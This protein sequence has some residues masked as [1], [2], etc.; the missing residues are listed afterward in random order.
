M[1]EEKPKNKNLI[2]YIEIAAVILLICFAFFDD[3]DPIYQSDIVAANYDAKKDEA[4]G[5][6]TS[7]KESRKLARELLQK[8]YEQLK[9]LHNIIYRPKAGQWMT[10][11]DE[12]GQAFFDYKKEKGSKLK[13]KNKLIYIKKVGTFTESQDKVFNKTIEFIKLYFDCQVKLLEE[14]TESEIPKEFK[15]KNPYEGHTQVLTDYVL[16][17]LLLKKEKSIQEDALAV[18]ALTSFDLYPHDDWNFVFGQAYLNKKAGVWSIYR[19]GDP[20]ESAE[21][22]TRC[23]LRTI[24]TATHEISH[25]LGQEHCISYECNMNGSNSLKESD[26]KPLSLC[27]MC[28][29]K[30]CWYL[31]IDATKRF[32]KLI[33]FCQNNGLE[34]EATFYKK[35]L[36]QLISNQHQKDQHSH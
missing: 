27:P 23:L 18:I 7:K 3:S 35:S 28:L 8:P 13:S 17:E 24:K 22:F 20:A 19:Y 25:T 15:R 10:S 36:T 33:T 34:N 1:A 31:N 30:L 2:Y 5:N 29:N 32:E 6:W 11:H 4:E 9:P 26:S 12:K 14:A 21:S 16:D